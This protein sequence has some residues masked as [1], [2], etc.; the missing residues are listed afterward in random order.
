MG[1]RVF[2]ILASPR[3]TFQRV[4]AD[5]RWIGILAL[6]VGGVAAAQPARS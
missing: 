3:E 2:G 1:T 5:P 6:S 4:M